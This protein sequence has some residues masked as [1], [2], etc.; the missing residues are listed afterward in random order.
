MK[1]QWMAFSICVAGL[2]LGPGTHNSALGQDV[3]LTADSMARYQ[4]GPLDDPAPTV[5]VNPPFNVP[6]QSGALSDPTGD[7]FSFAR[8]EASFE[9]NVLGGV[10]K[11]YSYASGFDPNYDPPNDVHATASAHSL[12]DW[13]TTSGS[14]PVNTPIAVQVVIPIDGTLASEQYF[15]GSLGPNDVFARASAELKADGLSLYSGS[16]TA[17]D[18]IP[19]SGNEVL[20]DS[21]D[22][23]GD[24]APT[25]ILSSGLG[26]VSGFEINTADVVTFPAALGNVFKIEFLLETEGFTIG[27]F[28]AFTEANFASTSSYTLMAVDPNSG[29]PLDVQFEPVFALTGDL[30]GDGFV[31]I[32][33][34]NIVLGNWNQ[35]VPPANPLAD[36]SGDGFVGIDD[37]NEVLGNWNAGT[38]PGESANIPEPTTIALLGAA[39]L[40]WSRRR[41]V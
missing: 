4:G 35:S 14:L 7:G 15:S 12:V 22:W 17:Y 9:L 26:D 21:G 2:A 29:A 40:L 3:T 34:L 31:G 41:A 1:T 16:A 36:P 20:L 19:G 32:D 18:P 25:T 8:G 24:F 30:D 38:P 28:E 13:T 6:A 23:T 33:D 5:L 10:A 39:G 11:S 27:P 37:L